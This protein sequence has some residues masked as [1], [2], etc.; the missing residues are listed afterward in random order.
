MKC[1]RWVWIPAQLLTKLSDLGQV[2]WLF[3]APFFL[4]KNRH[5]NSVL[6]TEPT[7]HKGLLF[8]LF[9]GG[10]SMQRQCQRLSYW[11]LLSA[12]V[13]LSASLSYISWI[14]ESDWHSYLF[15]SDQPLGLKPLVNAQVL[16]LPDPAATSNAADDTLFLKHLTQL[17]LRTPHLLG[18]FSDC[19]FSVCAYN[20]PGSEHWSFSGL[21][22]WI[23]LY[24][25]F[26]GELISSRLMAL[27]IIESLVTPKCVFPAQ[28]LP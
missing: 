5:H 17:A 1:M 18:S 6:G 2:S 25:Y 23:S 24:T 14:R 9:A 7:A 3:W 15:T 20:S 22:S 19:L 21:S 13:S 11:L 16:V 28:T 27:I 26:L 4:F 10:K 12:A 8:L